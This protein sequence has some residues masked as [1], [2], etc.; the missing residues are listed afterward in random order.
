MDED[1]PTDLRRLLLRMD[2]DVAVMSALLE[3]VDAA[4]AAR[5]DFPEAIRVTVVQMLRAGV[6]GHLPALRALRALAAG[7]LSPQ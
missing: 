2:R 1:L 5:P 3:R 6:E 4:L 7:G